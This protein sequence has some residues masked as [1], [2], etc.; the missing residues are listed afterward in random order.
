M[1]AKKERKPTRVT[2]VRKIDRSVAKK[3]IKDLGMTQL[4][5][6]FLFIKNK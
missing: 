6:E 5:G 1:E 4:N 3:N 2:G